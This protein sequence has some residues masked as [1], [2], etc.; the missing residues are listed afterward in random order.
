MIRRT[1]TAILLVCSIVAVRVAA[2]APPEAKYFFPA[3]AARGAGVEVTAAGNF[4]DWPASAWVNRP[5]VTVMPAAD[6]GKFSFSVAEDAVPGVY[7]VRLYSAA[8]SAAPLPFIV[9]TL[10]EVSEQEP[11]DQPAKAQALPSATCTINGRL[12]KGGDVDTFAVTLTKGQTLVGSVSA[13]E[14]LGSPMDSVLQI[15]SPRGSVLEQN[16]DERGLDSLLT[17]TA[18]A[19]G[20]YLA[21]IFAFPASPD[22]SISF[23]GGETFVYRLT[24]TTGGFLDGA[25][26]LAVSR[27]RPTELTA[28]GWGLAEP[29]ARRS[30]APQADA[31][32]DLF[33]P[34]WAGAMMLPVVDC[35]SL[36]EVEPN[37]AAHPQIVEA[38]L[39]ISGRIGERGDRDAFRFHLAKGQAWQFKVES[40]RLGYP[41]DAVLELFDASGKSLAR[42]DD[43]G[44]Q[45]D[46]ELSFTPPSDGDYTLVV[47]DLYEHGGPRFFYRLSIAPIEADFA[48]SV[49]E[50]SY[51]FTPEK[52]LEI[53]VTIDRRHGFAGEIE[54][55]VDGLP[56]GV[57]AAAVKSLAS[58]DT[59]KSLKVLISG[60]S[61]PFSGPIRITGVSAAPLSRSHRA[62]AKL[63]AAAHLSDL[64]LT[65]GNK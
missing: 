30:I 42:A 45:P 36:V 52:P 9:G 41:L 31:Q 1:G 2:A 6:K 19:D 18:P 14:T 62:E 56:P 64:W 47:S 3:G 60:A 24:L 53:A 32:F 5:G 34:Q 28:Y 57:T 8:G 17:F 4:P 61:P 16:D 15:V 23:A 58:G 20:V 35:R 22:A 49:P 38:P 65:V 21:R 29:D 59:A 63:P 25:L 13:H 26:P 40:R 54:L 44:Q 43:A 37:D 48:L 12:E 11:S 39:A 27:T 33:S 51:V 10:P 46:A 55:T 7:W 50:H